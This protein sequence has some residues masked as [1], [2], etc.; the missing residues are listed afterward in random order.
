MKSFSIIMLWFVCLITAT[1]VMLS[2]SKIAQ[3]APV[4]NTGACNTNDS[5]APCFAHVDDILK[6]QRLLLPIDDL[7]LSTSIFSNPSLPTPFFVGP[8]NQFLLDTAN[9]AVTLPVPAP[10]RITTA[11]VPSF[12]TKA[13]HVYDLPKDTIVTLASN[14]LNVSAQPPG[15]YN[16]GYS[17][18]SGVNP[19]GLAMADYSGDGYD[20]MAVYFSIDPSSNT[21]AG[22]QIFTAKDVQKPPELLVGPEL[23]KIGNSVFPQFLD[24]DS[25]TTG[26]FNG[27]GQNE[28]AIVYTVRINNKLLQVRLDIFKVNPKDLSIKLVGSQIFGNIGD[29]NT[30]L[31]VE[32]GDFDG[33]INVQT[34]LPDDELV[35]LFGQGIGIQMGS[36]DVTTDL[37]PILKNQIQ[38][39]QNL[40]YYG[41]VSS[42]RI[43]RNGADI[44]EQVVVSYSVI[45]QG[46]L[47]GRVVI[48]DLSSDLQFS[49]VS[50]HNVPPPIVCANAG[51]SGYI[52]GLAVG[53]FD[54]QKNNEPIFPTTLQ[55]AVLNVSG[56]PSTNIMAVDILS[57]TPNSG[58]PGQFDIKQISTNVVLNLE[59]NF[60]QTQTLS[61]S[62]VAA[63]T[64]GRSLR[65]GSPEKA[66]ITSHIQP[67]T[68]LGLPPMHVD[69]ITA[70]GDSTPSVVN[71]SVF[72][73]TFNS[74]YDFQDKTGNQ[75]SRKSTTSYTYGYKESADEK[76]TYGIPD[77][78][79]VTVSAKQAAT[80]THESNVAKSFNTYQ[81]ESFSLSAAT[82]FDDLV[83]ASMKQ[84][85]IYSY[86]VIGQC[87]KCPVGD[88]VCAQPA[89]NCPAGERPLV[90]QY[91]GPDN[92]IHIQPT[93]ARGLEWYQPVHEPGNLLSYPGSLAQLRADQPQQTGTATSRL[94]LLTAADNIWGSQSSEQVSIAWTA[95]GGNDQTT[96]T[97]SNHSFDAS[98]SVSGEVDIEPFGGGGSVSF[99]YN[100]SK[101]VS[102]LYSHASSY[103]ASTGVVLH[104]GITEGPTRTANYLYQGQAFIFGQ[105]APLGTIQDDI[106][107]TAEIKA[108]GIQTV[109]YVVD[110]L[111]TGGI[112]SGSWWKQAYTVAP[113][114]ALNH[115]QRW[116][117]NQA[118]NVNA[119]QVQFNCPVGFGSSFESPAC[120]P[121]QKSPNPTNVAEASFYQMK[122]L[123]VTPGASSN[124][125][126]IVM[127]STGDTV[128]LRARVYNYSLAAMPADTSVN[129][130]FYAQP[131]DPVSGTFQHAPNNPNTFA[132]AVFIGQESLAP[133]PAFCGGASGTEDPCNDPAAPR[134][135][136][137]ATTQWD[138]SKLPATESDSYWKFWVVVWMEKNSALVP[139]I[140]DHGLKAMPGASLNSLADVA[141]ET[142]SNN[143]GFYNQVFTLTM[144]AGQV[145][146]TSIAELTQLDTEVLPP[147]YPVLVDETI[148]VQANHTAMGNSTDSVSVLFYDGDPEQDGKLFEMENIPRIQA[149]SPFV[150]RVPFRP[151]SCG[152]QILYVQTIPSDGSIPTTMDNVTFQ[153]T[154]EPGNAVRTLIQ[155]VRKLEIPGWSKQ[156]LVLLLKIAER[157][158]HRDRTPAGLNLLDKFIHAV[159]RLR[160][161][162][163]PEAAADKMTASVERIIGCME[164]RP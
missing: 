103:E 149:D 136:V 6:G 22:L 116:S 10:D 74:E 106:K 154:I 131:W 88:A 122:G 12:A 105:N 98:V 82:Q 151:R 78:A 138:T 21:G 71:V 153:V 140:E 46:N 115:P 160:P 108:Q 43:D 121:N 55:I 164:S 19:I 89:G 129:V 163:I 30:K 144:P 161:H 65:L 112:Q 146:T 50:N 67:D 5:T 109:G 113:D 126:Q 51:L 133:I 7:I 23:T 61:A 40:I 124:G 36:F 18:E 128:T 79:S 64:Q 25:I 45:T 97:L 27:D 72:P 147:V 114:V 130:Q 150:T 76:I 139:E 37:Q 125:P 94:Q 91:S 35:V 157:Q 132:K 100:Q 80:Q 47:L 117:Q 32:A 56:C 11:S 90:L 158:F 28:I 83:A 152:T 102:S 92:I 3:A 155:R 66:T 17:F 69:W 34:G 31:I 84:M 70:V 123:F 39:A 145:A 4:V 119:Q 9:S 20:D 111:S 44:S 99:D 120:S 104:R 16:I 52:R 142:Y 95:G 49:Q 75:G 143:L 63:D 42:A 58:S 33:Q 54:Q 85:N 162:S 77:I 159:E 81:G 60:E 8:V 57:V 87:V 101:A 110:P 59:G 15:S 156:R 1:A 148:T 24:D 26:D 2:G 48:Y 13:G 62:L 14:T 134:N 127:A 29:T 68:V 73:E 41:N 107:Q 135:W 86:P 93:S 137:Y 118:S 38:V 141:I 96:G 53:N